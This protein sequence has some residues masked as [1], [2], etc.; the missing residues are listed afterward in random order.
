MSDKDNSLRK[1]DDEYIKS[2]LYDNMHSLYKHVCMYVFISEMAIR[3]LW[4]QSTAVIRFDLIV[5]AAL[6]NIV[7]CKCETL[8]GHLKSNLRQEFAIGPVS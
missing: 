7:I 1:T 2:G 5:D 8:C 6:I 3:Y 4:Q